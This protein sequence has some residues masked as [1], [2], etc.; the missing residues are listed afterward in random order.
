M[1]Y[2]TTGSAKLP[3]PHGPAYEVPLTQ[4]WLATSTD[5]GRTWS[6]RRVLDG[7]S[8]IGHAL[9]ASA[10]DRQG[11]LYAAFS[12]RRRGV[13]RTTVYLIHS[14]THGRTWSSPAAVTSSLP[15]NVLPALALTRHGTAYLS[16]YGSPNPDFRSSHAAWREMFAQTPDPLKSNPS[17]TVTRITGPK[18]VHV[19]GI[20]SAGAF[21][22]DTGA[23][24]GLRDFQ[25]IAV[26]PCSA[27][28]L[29]W[30]QDNGVK[31]TQTATRASAC[32]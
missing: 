23:N 12:A 26:G 3:A 14:T 2:E 20:N 10:I 4:I 18:P 31:A 1:L 6:N 5:S 24:W 9:V 15:S 8:I 16:W 27:P 30:A 25:G 32:G 29:T 13:T 21:G 22:S 17:F 11:H 19:G 7:H 28:V